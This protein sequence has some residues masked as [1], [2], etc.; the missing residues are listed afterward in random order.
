LL[1]PDQVYRSRARQRFSE[2]VEI[3]NQLRT[4]RNVKEK[5]RL[6]KKLAELL[7]EAKDD[8]GGEAW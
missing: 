2:I 8:E 7:R 6:R 4:V 5:E 1:Q 3:T